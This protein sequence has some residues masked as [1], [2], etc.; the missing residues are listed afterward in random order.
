MARIDVVVF[1]LGRYS[2]YAAGFQ[3]ATRIQIWWV[4]LIT[5]Y[6]CGISGI[7]ERSYCHTG[8]TSE[9]GL[10][11]EGRHA[12]SGTELSA[13]FMCVIDVRICV[14]NQPNYFP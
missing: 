5:C 1:L 3:E 10:S 6:L 4:F 2:Y 11:V 13:V 7:G 8:E 12:V 9:I 14:A